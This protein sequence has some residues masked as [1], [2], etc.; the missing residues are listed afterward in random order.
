MADYNFSTLSP[1]DFE[2]LIGSLL[3]E[4]DGWNLEAFGHGP[5]G[6][7]DLRA[8]LDDAKIVVQ[9]KHYRGSTFA[10]LRR[11]LKAEIT[12]IKEEKPTR[13]ILATSQDLSRTQKDTLVA[14]LH[15][16]VTNPS[17]VLAARDLNFLLDDFPQV[18]QR[19]FKLWMA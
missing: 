18:E 5:D 3:R 16:W 13:Y 1:K 7:V 8:I 9:C 12:K 14:D 19:H 2:L 10:D 17:D 6:G 11:A 15:P 4:R